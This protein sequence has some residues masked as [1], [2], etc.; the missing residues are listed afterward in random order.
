M[1]RIPAAAT[2]VTP[3]RPPLL[4][5]DGAPPPGT[6]VPARARRGGPRPATVGGE[7]LLLRVVDLFK[8]HRE[9]AVET[10]ALRGVRLDIGRGEV[11]SLM[12]P[13]G[14]GKS[15]L[16]SI[17]GGLALPTSG[18]VLLGD[19]DITR[20]DEAGRA[21]LRARRIGIVRQTGNLI[22]FLTALEN[23]ELAMRLAGAP[24]DTRHRAR[25]LLGELGLGARL[26]H[27]PHQLSGGVAQRA[28]VAAALVNEPELLLADEVTGEL[29]SGSAEQVVEVLLEASRERGLGVLLVTHDRRLAL[30]AP[31]RLQ[32]S[33]G[34]VVAAG[35]RG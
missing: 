22:P 8:V 18:Q 1:R 23:V 28:A 14:S 35:R 25:D 2:A 3:P 16:L 11:V 24:R 31:R 21:R 10:V 26:H 12:G 5:G 19:Q 4:R 33:D 17:M 7:R 15:T 13:S 32:I 34:T 6:D 9:G 20:L 29:D 30:R 27:R